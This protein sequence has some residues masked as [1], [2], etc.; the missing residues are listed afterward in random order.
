M[1][2]YQKYNRYFAQVAGKMEQFCEQELAQLGAENTRVTYRGVYFTADKA[3]L[4]RINYMSRLTTR[5]LAP[6]LTFSCHSARYLKKTAANIAWEEILSLSRT[7]AITASVSNSGIK[8][9]LYAALCLKDGIADYFTAACGKRPDVDTEN[10]D[11]RFNLHIERNKAVVSLDISGDSLHKRSY[12]LSAGE[13]PMQETLAAALVRLSRWSGDRPLWDCMCGSGTILCEALMHYCKIPAQYLRRNFGFFH[14]P[15]YDPDIWEKVKS[16][17][18]KDMRPLPGGLIR[19]SDKSE[20]AVEIASKNLGRLPYHEAVDLT[21]APFQETSSY[22][23]G[24]VICN[25]PYGIRLGKRKEVETLYRELGNFLKKK[26]NGTSAYIYIGDTSLWKFIG[27]KPSQRIPLANGPLQG[28][29]LR[30]DSYKIPFR[31]PREHMA[32]LGNQLFSNTIQ[33]IFTKTK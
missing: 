25:P 3:T 8:H 11:I 16:E 24:L 14:M 32:H 1:F 19:G 4:Y 30:I 29:L 9:S 20:K 31:K 13:A 17:C 18:V 10:P 7:F 33:N 6:L 23:Q 5:V 2:E 12:R 28:E 22:E 21:C 27:L 26:C 15:G